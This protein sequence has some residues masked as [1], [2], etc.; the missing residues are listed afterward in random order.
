MVTPR[1]SVFLPCRNAAATL[2]AAITS[3]LA[4][5]FR[6]FELIIVDHLSEDETPELLRRYA[7]RDPRIQVLSSHATFVE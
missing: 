6:D 4:Q 5:T 7:I 2:P 1:V 3:I